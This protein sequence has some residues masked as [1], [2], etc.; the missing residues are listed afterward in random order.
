M[1]QKPKYCGAPR[2]AASIEI[3]S[4]ASQAASDSVLPVFCIRDLGIYIDGDVS[5]SRHVTTT[6]SSY[7]AVLSQLSSIRRSVSRS[8]FESLVVAL[9][10]PRLDYGNSTLGG[11]PSRLYYRLK[12]VFNT[13]A[14]LVFGDRFSD[15]ITPLLQELHWLMYPEII[16]YNK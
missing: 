11:I 6:I 8:V 4:A 13:A 12:S 14:L 2:R 9:V 10:R 15:H 7:F 1:R 5:T 3:P 16:Q